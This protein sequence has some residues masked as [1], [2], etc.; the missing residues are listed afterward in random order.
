MRRSKVQTN[1]YGLT[2]REWRRTV[3]QELETFGRRFHDLPP[4]VDEYAAWMEGC[5]GLELLEFVGFAEG[6]RSEYQEER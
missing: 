4:Y 5:S 3:S 1:E 6:F 2:F